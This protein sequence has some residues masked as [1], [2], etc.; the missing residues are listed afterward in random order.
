M[1]DGT[2]SG[3][4]QT[5]TGPVEPTQLGIT[6]VHEHIFHNSVDTYFQKHPDAPER[7]DQPVSIENR[8]W[9]EHN[10]FNNRENLVFDDVHAAAYEVDL[11]AQ[12]GGGTLVE[13]SCGG[14][15]SDPTLAR[16]LSRRTGVTIVKGAGWYIQPSHPERLATMS[17][18]EIA[19]EMVQAVTSGIDGTDVRAGVLGEIGVST[20]F[21]PE[22]KRV[23]RAALAAQRRTGVPVS[24][25]P[26]MGD[27]VLLEIVDLLRAEGADMSNII[28]GHL[29][30]FGFSRQAQVRLAETGCFLAYDNF[31][32][33][34]FMPT[35]TLGSDLLHPSDGE[36]LKGIQFLI[37]QDYLPQIVVAHD[38]FCKH[39]MA[40]YG[41]AGYSHII[42]NV[43]PV[44][45]NIGFN[46]E[47]ID[48][49][50][51][52]NPSRALTF[53]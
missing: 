45:R 17:E 41:G 33:T 32:A 20:P 4:V 34:H 5:V 11:F 30:C 28:M 18:G 8:W 21:H 49:I 24:I 1:P 52:G 26:G 53:A 13:L 48:A 39:D 14:M 29:D 38:L 36:R 12:A 50:L 2:L 27:E 51:V 46:E 19:D 25:H 37:E 35:Q 3:K 16:D 7:A 40:T 22:E 23:L 42:R 15:N 6:S 31:G 47:E 44:M 10:P 43:L 9:V